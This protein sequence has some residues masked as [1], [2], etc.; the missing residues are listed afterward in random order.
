MAQV[1]ASVNLPP[2]KAVAGIGDLICPFATS[3]HG[4]IAAENQAGPNAWVPTRYT[5]APFSLDAR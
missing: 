4:G 3:S 2:A 1:I 5:D